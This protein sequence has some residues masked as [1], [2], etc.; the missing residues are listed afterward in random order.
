[1]KNIQESISNLVESYKIADIQE[2]AES[3]GF[4]ASKQ[5]QTENQITTKL[6]L[7]EEH[8][9]ALKE[10]PD[11]YKYHIAS[12]WKFITEIYQ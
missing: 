7:I 1:M 11:E 10:N 12:M 4:Y 2:L 3:Q 5:E 6:N 8:A 9:L